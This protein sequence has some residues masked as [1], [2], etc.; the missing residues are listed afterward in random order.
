MLEA[1]V[2]VRRYVGR[3]G[4]AA[5]LASPL[6]QDA[7][8]RNIEVVGEAA[9]RVPPDYAAQHGS[10]PWRDITGMRHRLIHGYLKIN[11][12]TVWQAVKRDLPLL[13]RNLR[14]ILQGPRK[15]RAVAPRKRRKSARR[16]RP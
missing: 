6:L 10:I 9:G 4:R 3:K 8:I 5:F 15:A 11:L 16:A 13:E 1:I 7:V 12:D 2:R 14:A